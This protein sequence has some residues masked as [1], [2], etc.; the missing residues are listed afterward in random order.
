MAPTPQRFVIPFRLRNGIP[1]NDSANPNIVI[2]KAGFG[3]KDLGFWLALG[4]LC[5]VFGIE[6]ARLCVTFEIE[7]SEDA[8]TD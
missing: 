4:E 7:V 3:L 5:T 2:L 1:D 8:E 6:L